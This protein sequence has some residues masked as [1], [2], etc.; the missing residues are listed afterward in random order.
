[1]EYV[2]T[3]QEQPTGS[4][5]EYRAA[6]QRVLAAFATG[7]KPAS[8]TIRQFVARVGLGGYAVVETD[9]PA[10]LQYL[11]TAYAPV[12]FT[13]ERVVEGMDA[14]VAGTRGFG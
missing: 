7:Q 2:V 4:D 3:W 10:D 5:A 8:L 1:M 13:V 6:Q 12:S 14:V 11:T 9:E